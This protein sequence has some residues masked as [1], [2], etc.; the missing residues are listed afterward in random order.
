[1][2]TRKHMNAE[3]LY[4]ALPSIYKKFDREQKPVEYPLKRFIQLTEPGWQ[5]LDDKIKGMERLYDP[6]QTP[7]QFLD[8]LAS[9]WGFKFPVSKVA[10]S[11]GR[12]MRAGHI[13]LADMGA[14][15]VLNSVR[16]LTLS[17]VVIPVKAD[18]QTATSELVTL[19]LVQ[20]DTALALTSTMNANNVN[21][22]LELVPVVSGGGTPNPANTDTYFQNLK[23]VLT[24]LIREIEARGVRVNYLSVGR[25]LSTLES[26]ANSARWADVFTHIRSLYKGRIMYRT[27]KWDTTAQHA[28]KLALSFLSSPNLDAIAVQAMFEL[29]E[30]RR[31]TRE[32]LISCLTIGTTKASRG[33]KVYDQ[34]KGLFDEFGKPVFLADLGVGDKEYG[35]SR[36]WDPDTSDNY[37][38]A[39]AYPEGQQYLYEAYDDVFTDNSWFIGFAASDVSDTTS[40]YYPVAKPAQGAIANFIALATPTYNISLTEAEKRQFLDLLPTLYS[41]KS[42]KLVF[43]FLGRYVFGNETKVVVERQDRTVSSSGY[44]TINLGVSVSDGVLNLGEMTERYLLFADNFRP[45]NHKFNVTFTILYYDEFERAR[46]GDASHLERMAEL[47]TDAYTSASMNDTSAND[48]LLSTDVES[49][50]TSSTVD[51]SLHTNG[52]Q[53]VTT[54]LYDA[55][56]SDAS[57]DT[58]VVLGSMLG[59][60]NS[61]NRLGATFRLSVP[62]TETVLATNT[63]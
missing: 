18:M 6:D 28:A 30:S 15:N 8:D 35:A 27:A 1:M 45:V 42:S 2:A 26:E 43:T 61:A 22:I 58:V 60:T 52:L 33:Q 41:Y 3:R 23:N 37:P 31:Y 4:A 14:D 44:H 11:T 36:P 16:S 59:F 12:K 7:S 63:I 5:Y 53:E 57:T 21:V 32:E 10:A 17:T 51:D 20:M 46:L 47:L 49:Y 54:E 13:S 62:S 9:M 34:V 56:K 38:G 19:D 25:D 39:L 29:T 55:V 24:R 50:T 40:A 48:T